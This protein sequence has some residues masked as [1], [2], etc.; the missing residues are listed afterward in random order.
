MAAFGAGH[1]GCDGGQYQN[2]FQSLTE[3]KNPNIQKRHSRASVGPCGIRRAVCS[4]S[5]PRKHCE[6]AK[7]SSDYA[8]AQGWPDFGVNSI[9]SPSRL[10]LI[11]CSFLAAGCGP[12]IS[13]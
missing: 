8:D 11:D 9:T 6:H 2:A 13:W 4:N 5:L 7:R 3:D 12:V 10:L 1:A